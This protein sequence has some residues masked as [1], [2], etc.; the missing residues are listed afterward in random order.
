MASA[1]NAGGCAGDEPPINASMDSSSD[2][3]QSGTSASASSGESSGDESAG[4]GGFMGRNDPF[5]QYDTKMSLLVFAAF[6][7]RKG[8]P[9]AKAKGKGKSPARKKQ[10]SGKS[11]QKKARKSHGTIFGGKQSLRKA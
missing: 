8:K 5:K 11:P 6:S 7:I 1:A 3:E 2:W 4:P 10:S 9:A